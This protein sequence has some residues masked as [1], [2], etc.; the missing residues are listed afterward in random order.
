MKDRL[1]LFVLMLTLM[2][3]RCA[4]ADD[5]PENEWGP[6]TND[7]QMS[8]GL[9]N[10][11]HTI[12][13]GQPC[14]LSVRFKN[15]SKSK[16]LEVEKMRWMEGDHTYSFTVIDPSGKDIA[17]KANHEPFGGSADV[18][19][20]PPG[21]T[22]GVEFNLTAV[23]KISTTGNYRVIAKKVMWSFEGKGPF[24]VVS[25]PLKITIR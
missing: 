21:Q 11:V 19:E 17:P 10:G 9:R 23:C 5:G 6:A 14:I 8:I 4:L 2:G 25:N 22:R 18:I 20:I 24:Q 12:T 7:L 1:T 13:N 16:L 15:L 3:T